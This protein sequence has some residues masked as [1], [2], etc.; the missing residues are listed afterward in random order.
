M[1]QRSRHLIPI[2]VLSLAGV[3]CTTAPPPGFT[4]ADREQIRA[5]TEEA[6]AMAN[7]S[8]DYARYAGLYY[9]QDVIVMPPNGEAVRGRDAV[10]RWNEEFPPY[11]NLQF[12]QVQ[13][14]GAGDIA[15][16]YG[17]YSMVMTLPDVEGPVPDHGK[18]IEIWRRQADGSW[19]VVLDI[20]NSDVPLSEG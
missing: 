9:A 2:T 4:D 11:E 20:F 17:T 16:V 14:D 6:M 18:Y 5:T 7:S 19:K 8:K 1:L 15:Y 13:V 12:T 10:V 3:S